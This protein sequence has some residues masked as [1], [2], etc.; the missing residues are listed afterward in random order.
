MVLHPVRKNGG[1]YRKNSL[2]KRQTTNIMKKNILAVTLLALAA[3]MATTSC[4]ESDIESKSPVF[5]EI[6]VTPAKVYTGQYAYATVSYESAGAYIYSSKYAWDIE[7]GGSG[8]WSETDPTKSEPKFKFSVPSTAGNYRLTFKATQINYSAQAANGTIYGSA[9]SVSK[10]INVLQADAINANWGD[11][12]QHLDSVLS[13]KDT[14]TQKIWTGS[15]TYGSEE[16][17]PTLQAVRLYSFSTSTQGLDKVEETATFNVIS[18]SNW[19]EDADGQNGH[20]ESE[21]DNTTNY[22]A[23]YAMIGAKELSGYTAVKETVEGDSAYVYPVSTWKVAETED[24]MASI[25]NAFADGAI[26]Y[27]CTLESDNS[28]CVITISGTSKAITFKRTFTPLD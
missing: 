26:T 5:G 10:V 16:G 14:L 28:M 27:R 25:V 12:R 17:T 3:G 6:N 9:N 11:T 13:V 21:Y 1:G 19:V 4:S 18:H 23:L 24:T 8:S 2:N 15:T 22:K 7:G 20:M